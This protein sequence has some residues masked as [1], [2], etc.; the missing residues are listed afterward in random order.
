ML[1]NFIEAFQKLY[2][3]LENENALIKQHR[4]REV[5]KLYTIKEKLWDNYLHHFDTAFKNK[6]LVG[7]NKQM[8]LRCMEQLNP[9]AS[10]NQRL[11]IEVVE[12]YERNINKFAKNYANEDSLPT[13]G[14]SRS[15]H[16]N[17]GYG[18]V[19]TLSCR[20]TALAINQVL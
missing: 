10:E 6:S 18:M 14:Y 19:R 11:I 2:A 7:S 4:I 17:K 1:E 9:V 13:Q 8:V 15:G 3:F 16:L 20:P 12:G 5:A